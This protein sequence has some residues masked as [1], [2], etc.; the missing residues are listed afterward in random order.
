MRYIDKRPS[1]HYIVDWKA[2]RT[3]AGQNLA[4]NDFDHKR[5]LNDDLRED[6]HNICCYCQQKITHFQGSNIGG[7]HNEHLVPENGDFGNFALQVD[8][9]NLFACCNTTVGMG[10]KEKHKRHCGDAKGDL[11][12][13]GFIQETTCSRYFKYN[14][15]GEIIPNGSYPSF[16]EYQANRN[17]LPKDESEALDTLEVLNLNSV[18]MVNDRKKDF[19]KLF[20]V[21]VRLN[22]KIID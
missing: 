10:K 3:A 1:P 14:N 20:R 13:R 15:L 18:T 16:K 7:S 22:K 19:D 2:A 5:Q 8:Y 17:A 11:L 12:I 21:M 6:Q 9:N 4:Y